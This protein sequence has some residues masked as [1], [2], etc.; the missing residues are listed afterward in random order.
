[1]E[2]DWRSIF[3]KFALLWVLRSFFANNPLANIASFCLKMLAASPKAFV[4]QAMF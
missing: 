4:T 2:F 3:V 1:M